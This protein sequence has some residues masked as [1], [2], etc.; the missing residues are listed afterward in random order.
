M[1]DGAIWFI[2]VSVDHKKA[3][4]KMKPLL[5]DKRV[6]RRIAYESSFLTVYEDDVLLPNH[7]P[8]KRVVV[9]HIGAAAVLPIM[10]NG[11]VVLIRQHRYAAGVD[12][13]EM[14]AGKKDAY[15]EDPL[16]CAK[17]ELLEETGY[18]GATFSYLTTIHSAIGFSDETIA[19]YR[20]E[21]LKKKAGDMPVDEEEFL[22]VVTVS[23]E[24]ALALVENGTIT[25]AKTIVALLWLR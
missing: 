11:D 22:E 21:G 15:D 17:R 23:F 25:D 18:E 4:E 20:A 14:P 1:F 6:N 12:S 16:V 3:G 5:K 9:A 10:D 19:L 13:Y 24:K 2:M 8:S 7:K